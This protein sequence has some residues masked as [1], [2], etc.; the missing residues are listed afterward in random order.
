MLRE[1]HQEF[2][3]PFIHGVG[4]RRW[5]L[6]SEISTRCLNH[7]LGHVLRVEIVRT[8]THL[9]QERE[10]LSRMLSVRQR[11]SVDDS[12]KPH[13]LVQRMW[14]F[15]HLT[16]HVQRFQIRCQGSRREI[17]VKLAHFVDWLIP[18]I[19]RV[20]I[21]CVEHSKDAN[22]FERDFERGVE[23]SLM[24]EHISKRLELL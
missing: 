24:R 17:P 6:F 16:I 8:R 4:G 19:I 21:N 7:P 13:F 18:F 5:Q 22:R 3:D 14:W 20:R 10:N 9:T 2:F 12:V 11:Q 1:Q 23:I 15:E